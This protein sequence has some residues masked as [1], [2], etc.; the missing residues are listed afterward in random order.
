VDSVAH[1]PAQPPRLGRPR[2][3]TTTAAVLTA[4]RALVYELGY[5]NLTIE[6]VA[7]RAKAG[8][9]TIYRWWPSKATLVVEAFA[10]DTE[11]SVP[12]SDTPSV[13]EDFRRHLQ[14]LAQA[15]TT[16][17]GQ[18]IR[19]FIGHGQEDPELL[20]ALQNHILTPLR[21]A[22][23]QV[24]LRGIR[25]GQLRSNIY[26]ELALDV[27]YGP[28]LARHLLDPTPIPPDYVDALCDSVMT[29]L[30]GA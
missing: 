26:P 4:T 24:L 5:A 1:L 18:L 29:G 19:L 28:L 23:R 25:N 12:F 9:A 21:E 20:H 10:N 15:L 6:A 30:M 17:H 3:H 16:P 2:S 8:K 22:A 27:L 14:L 11:L 13:V 7:T